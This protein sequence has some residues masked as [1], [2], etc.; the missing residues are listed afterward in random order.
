MEENKNLENENLE[1]N[2]SEN[3]EV[4]NE[5]SV[6]NSEK[7]NSVESE[8]AASSKVEENTNGSSKKIQSELKKQTKDTFN[9]AKEQMKN[10]NFKEEASAGKN[11][12]IRLFKE[13]V[14]VI[15]EVVKDENNKFFKTSIIFVAVWIIVV[16]LDSIIFFCSSKSADFDFW[17][18]LK[19]ILSPILQIVAMTLIIFLLNMKEKKSFTNIITPVVIAKIPLIFASVIDLLGFIGIRMSDIITPVNGIL[20]CLSIVLGY[21]VVKDITD[22]DDKNAFVMYAKVIGLYYLVY[23]VLSFAGISI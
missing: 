13:P 17:Y 10:I 5:N 21:F 9:T 22:S 14:D 11:L 12:I 15:K 4:N 19:R 20:E 1:E 23:F 18:T 7:E 6:N 8:N 16:L 3:K 2:Y